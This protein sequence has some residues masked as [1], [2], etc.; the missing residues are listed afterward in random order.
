MMRRLNGISKFAVCVGLALCA[1]GLAVAQTWTQDGPAPRYQT[2][3]VYDSVTDQMI[4]F[5]GWQGSGLPVFNDVWS[6]VQVIA[7]GQLTSVINTDWAQI[8]PTGTAPSARFGHSAIYDS[9]S[10]RMIVYAGASSS[11]TCLNDV[12]SLDTANQSGGTPSWMQ[13]SPTGTKPGKRMA[14]LAFYDATNNIMIVYGGTSC[15]GGYFSDVWT[16][17]HANGEGGTPAWTKL[18]LMGGGPAARESASGIYDPVNNSITVYGG[19][20]GTNALSDVWILNH[21]NGMGGTPKWTKLTPTGT[22]PAARTGA[23][24]VYDPGSN[25]MLIYG[26]VNAVGGTTWYTDTWAITNAN[27]TG[28]APAWVN[29]NASVS[30]NPTRRYHTAIYDHTMNDM[31]IFGGLSEITGFPPADQIFILSEAN[32]L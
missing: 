3:A 20:T 27:N 9:G 6:E 25:R 16:L 26:G 14:H 17:S 23:S 8:F 19:D 2:S 32:G 13:L 11:T 22:A 24:A 10:N 29:I 30:T 1:A 18:T 4:V 15:A 21:A 5:G 7:F 12:W 28:G 31:V